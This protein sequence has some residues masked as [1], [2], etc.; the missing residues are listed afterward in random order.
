MKQLFI[1]FWPHIVGVYELVVRS[2]PTHKN[3]SLLNGILKGLVFVS[4][5]LNNKAKTKK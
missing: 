2:I 3:I 1:E 5:L 4:D